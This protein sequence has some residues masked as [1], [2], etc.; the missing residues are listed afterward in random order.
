M[1]FG[2]PQGFPVAVAAPPPRRRSWLV[3][4]GIVLAV[5]GIVAL[6]VGFALVI[7]DVVDTATDS[8]ARRDAIVEIAVPGTATVELDD[9]SYVAFAL[10]EGLVTARL[11]QVRDLVEAVRGNF[12]EPV[13]TIVGPDGVALVASTPRVETLEDR[14]GTDAAS[15]AQFRVISPGAHRIEVVS[16]SPGGGG[17]VT[18]VILREADGLS[19]F[20]ISEGFAFGAVLLFVGGSA[21]TLGVVLLVIGL[22]RRSLGRTSR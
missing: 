13:I 18:S 19:A 17:P 4:S 21:L 3:I 11:D 12:A 1:S 7:F 5:L 6:I 2:A 20:G 10:G 14:P 8:G 15:V 9:G 22:V 16:G